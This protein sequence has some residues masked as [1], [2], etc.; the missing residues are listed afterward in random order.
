MTSLLPEAIEA[1]LERQEAALRRR[2][3]ASRMYTHE[4]GEFT[5]ARR[6]YRQLWDRLGLSEDLGSLTTEES[7]NVVRRVRCRDGTD[8]V[9][10]I[11]GH[12]REPGEGEVLSE[13]R[14]LG[15]RCVEPLTWGHTVMSQL[16][17]PA[18]ATYLL[19]R[20]IDLPTVLRPGPDWSL[21]R[22]TR[23]AERLIA[24]M[25]PFHEA[26]PHVPRTRTWEDRLQLHL[27]WSLPMLQ[28]R[29]FELP[30]GW[31]ATL[32]RLSR[33]GHRILHGDPAGGNVLVDADDFILLD[34]PGAI[35]GLPE[36]DVAQICSQLGGADHVTELVLV[37]CEL[38]AKLDPSAIAAFAG[39][40]FLT[41][42]GY[43]LASHN[44]PDVTTHGGDAPEHASVE[45]NTLRYLAVARELLVIGREYG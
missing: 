8:G 10:K 43:F 32:T 13:W 12:T 2:V 38:D 30:S 17:S 41:W 44:T 4:P 37:A 35:S 27:R 20:F 9:L 29:G 39:L 22:R 26:V 34:P 15:L 40:N 11:A 28:E 21:D 18:V 5:V 36:A 6:A 24:F 31:E 42:A 23:L 1:D 14:R 33:E 7:R 45:E 16:G 25:R 3:N 19:T